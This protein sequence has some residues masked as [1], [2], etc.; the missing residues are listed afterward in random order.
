MVSSFDYG[1][2]YILKIMSILESMRDIL[3]VV[4]EDV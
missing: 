2:I 1:D 4:R 3:P